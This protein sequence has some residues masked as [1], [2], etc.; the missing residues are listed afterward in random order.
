[1]KS[2]ALL[3]DVDIPTASVF[4]A[5]ILIILLGATQFPQ[6][7]TP[8]YLL[9]QLHIGS[10]LGIVAA[11]M[12][13]VI[14]LGRI[15]LSAPW[16]MTAAAMVATTAHDTLGLP[17]GG[18]LA[19]GLLVGAVV[20]A[21]NGFGVVMLNIPSIIWTLAMNTV[22]RGVIV[23]WMAQRMLNSQAPDLIRVLGQGKLFGLISWSVVI[24]VMISCAI[25][26]VRKR[27][28]VGRFLIAVGQNEKAAYLSGLPSRLIVFGA[29]VFAGLCSSLAGTLLAG[30]AGQAYLDMGTSYLLPAIAAVVVGGSS[31]LGGRGKYP[32][33]VGGVLLVTLL[34]SLLS[35]SQMP[36]AMRQIIFGALILGMVLVYSRQ[37]SRNS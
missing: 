33:T 26:W 29:F 37:E 35:I 31:I 3:R 32:G 5:C 16:T 28:P 25:L 9:Q 17:P 2:P 12:F 15:D 34:T 20:G 22:L 7:L 30:Y 13:V 14:L 10:F 1:M 18:G 23:F 27:T 11:G 19:M 8:R 6:L 21:V 4:I 36:E 24:W